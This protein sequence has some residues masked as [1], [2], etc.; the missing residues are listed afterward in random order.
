MKLYKVIRH[1]E[2][3]RLSYIKSTPYVFNSKYLAESLNPNQI[4]H[5][6]WEEGIEVKINKTS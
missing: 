5:Q 4:L 6:I 1:N 2:Y 3:R